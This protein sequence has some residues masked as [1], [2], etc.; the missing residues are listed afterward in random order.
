[1]PS[2]LGL[3]D[4]DKAILKNIGKEILENNNIDKIFFY[5]HL[6]RHDTVLCAPN[7]YDL[8]TL[9]HKILKRLE[10]GI[11]NRANLPTYK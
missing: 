10:F 1:M 8:D 11:L 4:N 7:K 6:F 5:Q 9:P 3:V 2:A